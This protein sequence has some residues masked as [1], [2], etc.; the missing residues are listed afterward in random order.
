MRKIL[1]VTLFGNFNIGNRLQNYALQTVLENHNCQVYNLCNQK[2]RV[3]LKYKIKNKIK[4]ILVSLGLFKNRF[5]DIV[6]QKS[7]LFIQRESKFKKFTDQYISNKIFIDS[8]EDVYKM[9]WN[10]IDLGITGS[11]QVWN[12]CEKNDNAFKYYYLYFLSKEKRMSYAPSFGFPEFPKETKELHK[13]YLLEMNKLS[14][15]EQDGCRIIKDL[16]NREA[17]YVLDPTLL[18]TKL[19]WQEIAKRPL[20]YDGKPYLLMYFLGDIDNETYTLI[21]KISAKYNLNI[22]NVLDKSKTEHYMTDP[23]EFIYLVDNADLVFT[24]S[25]HGTV[26]STIFEKDFIVFKRKGALNNMFSRIDN[27][28]KTLKLDDRIYEGQNIDY[29]IKDRSIRYE[30]TKKILEDMKES[31]IKYIENMIKN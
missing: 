10:D 30:F 22:V 14:C 3:S 17:E 9:D 4:D 12:I 21:K 1:L 16:C 5:S 25:F 15:R 20:F 19:Q 7:N 29:K 18:L 8:Y 13:K 26:F 28:L 31:S 2:K 23:Q 11:D 6:E 24:D 27:L